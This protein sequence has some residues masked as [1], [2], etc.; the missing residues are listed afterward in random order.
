MGILD[1]LLG[2]KEAKQELSKIVAEIAFGQ[3]KYEVSQLDMQFQQDTNRKKQPEGDVYGG[4]IVCTI[5]GTLS[6]QLIAWS[7]Y[8]D[9][10]VSGE[11]WF[12]N[13]N[14]WLTSGADFCILFTDAN[15][16]QVKR[17]V[18]VRNSQPTT[19]LVIAPRSVK[20]GSE[21]FENKWNK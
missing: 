3:E 6:K 14:H 20:I 21:K 18:S 1:K 8:T 15:C 13:R 16:L 5:R 11:I 9:K 12:Y 19:E 10:L 7:I 17:H 4:K 2:R